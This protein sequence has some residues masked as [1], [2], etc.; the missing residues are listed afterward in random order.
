MSDCEA[1]LQPADAAG[2]AS[3]P[4]FSWQKRLG[5]VIEELAG[6]LES[7]A[8][9]DGRNTDGVLSGEAGVED[10]TIRSLLL[11]TSIVR[12]FFLRTL[13]RF[14]AT[15]AGQ[16]GFTATE[17]TE[18]R[19]EAQDLFE[20]L[21]AAELSDWING[22]KTA[23]DGGEGDGSS[24]SPPARIRQRE[25][26]LTPNESTKATVEK[27]REG[28]RSVSTQLGK[29]RVLLP[30]GRDGPAT[31][32]MH[33]LQRMS[34][35]LESLGI[36]APPRPETA[37]LDPIR[38][39]PLAVR[40]FVEALADAFRPLAEQKGL[41]LAVNVEAGLQ[42]VD[43]DAP[44]LHR[45]ASLLIGNAVQ[46]T[47]KGGVSIAAR[48]GGGDWTLTVEDTGPGI[49]PSKLA[50][51]LTGS[52]M[53][54]DR[55]PHGLAVTRELVQLLGGHLD[56]ESTLRRGSR[57]TICLPRNRRAASQLSDRV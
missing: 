24:P 35:L 23:P 7:K 19:Q 16:G 15:Q 27:I 45:V 5:G 49:E 51:L 42:N 38:L 47:V 30:G 18:I 32:A 37:R 2:E 48:A 13:N 57:F 50:H 11:E 55:V 44:K 8:V 3:P 34:S 46:Y 25:P 1:L 14:Q 17:M 31:T 4:S 33:E 20:Q 40:S 6:R 28:L 21:V 56:A 53:G 39:A 54:P 52:A 22:S 43:T 41:R 10:T 36:P 29:M 12:N 9:G 26:I